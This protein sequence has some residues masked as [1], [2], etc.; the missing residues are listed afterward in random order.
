MKR[1]TII[2]KRLFFKGK[3]QVQLFFEAVNKFV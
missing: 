2:D 1:L 3:N